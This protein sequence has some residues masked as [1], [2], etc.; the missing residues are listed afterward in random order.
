MKMSPTIVNQMLERQPS[1]AR[2]L[3]QIFESRRKAVQEMQG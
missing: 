2:E 1:F 3:S